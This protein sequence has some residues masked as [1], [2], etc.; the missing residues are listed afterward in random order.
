MIKGNFKM[1][2]DVVSDLHVDIW[3]NQPINWSQSKKSDILI[4]AGD[5]ADDPY[6][7]LSE[8][9]RISQYYDVVL[10]IDGNHEHQKSTPDLD[11]SIEYFKNN[12]VDYTNIK[13]LY[14]Q[15]HII[16]NTAF[17]AKCG[18]WDYK[19]GEPRVKYQESKDYIQRKSRRFMGDTIEKQAHRDYE[20]IKLHVNN[21]Q[22]NDDIENI[23]IITHTLPHQQLISWGIYPRKDLAVGC[24]GNSL[25]SKIPEFDHK[26][27][28]K[29]WV[30]GHNHDAKDYIINRIRYISNPRGR[31]DDF[32]RTEYKSKAIILRQF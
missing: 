25:L 4:V 28:I 32:N 18:W 10:F 7:T 1:Q 24:Y 8:L 26:N 12:L 2:F 21:L 19:F 17:I 14:D 27:K 16:E 5:V 9:K 31:P 3:K 30:F 13:F 15:I 20:W 29:C 11:R 22:N 6:I 23:V